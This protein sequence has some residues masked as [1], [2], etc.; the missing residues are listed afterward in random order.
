MRETG[1]RPCDYLRR[2]LTGGWGIVPTSGQHANDRA[3]RKGGRILS[4]HCL[5]D[6]T[7]I[8]I[9]TKADRSATIILLPSEWGT[10]R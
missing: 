1:A 9:I 6:G 10:G 5:K 3:V 7:K 2:H 4:L 8:W